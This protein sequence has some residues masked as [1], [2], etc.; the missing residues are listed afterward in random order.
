MSSDA[1][2]EIAKLPDSLLRAIG[3]QAFD[4]IR[5]SL[6]GTQIA[7]CVLQVLASSKDST[8]ND[9]AWVHPIL[10]NC[11]SRAAEGVLPDTDYPC[12]VRL[13]PLPLP[14]TM[15]L[16]ANQIEMDRLWHIEKLEKVDLPAGVVIE[17]NILYSD[18]GID[19]SIERSL[20]WA[21]VERSLVV[22]GIIVLAG[23]RD[24]YVVVTIVNIS[25]DGNA[26]STD[27]AYFVVEKDG[28]SI[29]A[30]SSFTK[31]E[32]I[33]DD[34]ISNLEE[35]PCAGYERTIEE[36]VPLLEFEGSGAPSGL[37]LVGCA[38]VGKSHIASA[39]GHYWAR[40]GRPVHCVSLQGL[41]LRANWAT[42]EEIFEILLPQVLDSV[43]LIVDDLDVV[44]VENRDI[45]F[46]DS[47]RRLVLNSVLQS[48]DKL[49]MNGCRCLGLCR[50][51]SSLSEQLT[52]VGRLE[53]E[54]RVEPPTQMQREAL[55]QKMLV[56]IHCDGKMVSLWAGILA[57]MTPGC[58]A[59][60]LHRL[61]GDAWLLASTAAAEPRTAPTWNN[62]RDAADKCIPSQL[63]ELDVTKPKHA[64][65]ATSPDKWL[66]VHQES[67]QSFAGYDQV[68]K[69]IF[70]T[71][72]LPWKRHLSCGFRTD[73]PQVPPNGVLFHG[74]SGCGKTLAST[75]LAED[76][77][78][79]MVRV[80]AADVLDKWLGGSEAAI[81]S[82][83]SRARS[84][85]PCI[86]FFDEIDAIASNR[87]SG[88]ATGVMSR[89]L[90]TL[91][92][93]MDGV[94]SN[95][96]DSVLVIAC[97]NRLESLD[98]ALLRPGRLEEHVELERPDRGDARKILE[99][100]LTKMTMGDDVVLEDIVDGLLLSGLSAALI[101]GIAREAVVRSLRRTRPGQ[102]TQVVSRLDVHDAMQ[103]VG[104]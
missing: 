53:K 24:S 1:Y 54:M 62:L 19:L 68:K 73:P 63:V 79:P 76:V 26:L 57:K 77:G 15:V 45:S 30:S 66:Q 12:L 72:V 71:I 32:A 94:S 38:G 31:M 9:T 7:T 2:L 82:L 21:L 39:V 3:L 89:M 27:V 98:S 52:K 18:P 95:R 67:W 75:C 99:L 46:L 47:E 6:P 37:L 14:A 49:A 80:R 93:E 56:D 86:L 104:L 65:G 83:F 22:N 44:A 36:I 29:V 51:A 90:S 92:N 41:L 85:A 102:E 78:L 42:E 58:V 69:R 48:I 97:T 84:V 17:L 101:E 50:D 40:R 87:D 60:D 10:L 43:L 74:P 88:E 81:R 5:L 28:F 33:A 100:Y 25:V 23:H 61:C 34:M 8:V 59:G 16:E 11:L 96:K 35:S 13:R 91:L 64:T 20:R 4:T 55:L 70:R 103:S